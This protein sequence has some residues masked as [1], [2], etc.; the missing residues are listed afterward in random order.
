M[1]PVY[2][3]VL[4]LLAVAAAATA[5][6]TLG[7]AVQSPGG[8]TAAW[9]FC[10]SLFQIVL[11]VALAAT[12]FQAA[13]ALRDAAPANSGVEHFPRF[14]DYVHGQS[15][16]PSIPV[17]WSAILYCLESPAESVRR[18]TIQMVVDS[19]ESPIAAIQCWPEQKCTD[20]QLKTAETLLLEWADNMRAYPK[21]TA[22][23]LIHMMF[24]A[25]VKEQHEPHFR[26]IARPYKEV[27]PPTDRTPPPEVPNLFNA[28]I[29]K[30]NGVVKDTIL[31]WKPELPDADEEP[32]EQVA[33]EPLDR[34][35][36]AAA[37]GA[38]FDEVL[39]YVT[40]TVAAPRTNL[41]LANAEV[42]VGRFLHEMRWDALN[43]ALELRA[44]AC[45]ERESGPGTPPLHLP[46]ENTA[47]PSA[48]DWGKKYRRMRALGY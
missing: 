18:E 28:A 43:L 23:D 29:D 14:S 17:N 11:V 36:F 4:T 22:N 46:P 20:L 21:A 47:T 33:L 6:A 48:G 2:R 40:E 26:T 25:D 34:A 5:L 3:T 15:P 19:G 44:P 10:L 38:K 32:E 8:P 30:L 13:D 31:D 37:M 12:A 1:N 9:L 35:R 39:G 41:D 45:V 24:E 42:E 27:V 7:F 16:G